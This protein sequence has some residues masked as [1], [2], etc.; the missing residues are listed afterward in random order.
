MKIKHAFCAALLFSAVGPSAMAET[1]A[2]DFETFP[3]EAEMVFPPDEA[4]LMDAGGTIE[5]WVQA[6]WDGDP[7]YD[8]VI[9]SNVGPEGASYMMS[10][11]RDRDGLG[12]LSGSAEAII[13]FDFSD[14]RGHHV[15]VS[16]YSDGAAVFID[17]VLVDV[18]EF[19]LQSLPS[20]AFII[21]SAD[22]ETAP[23]AGSIGAVRV[24]GLPIEQEVLAEFALKDVLSETEGDHPGIDL[25][26][27]MSDFE[28]DAFLVVDEMIILPP[29][30]AQDGD[31]N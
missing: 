29:A 7:G 4:L 23:F 8:P 21:G 11:L 15:A 31:A 27:A 12:L 30:D 19:T 3:S 13:P 18:N 2:P 16:F 20:S 17:G 14:G 25:L 24:F 10:V 6:D 22:G 28:N 1:Y 26:L 9:L 5:F